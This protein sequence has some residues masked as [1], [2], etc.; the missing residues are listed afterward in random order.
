MAVQGGRFGLIG[1][2]GPLEGHGG[3]FQ[4]AVGEVAAQQGTHAVRGD[5]MVAAT[6][7][8][9]QPGQGLSGKMS[10]RRT[11]RQTSTS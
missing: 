5:E 8:A 11:D 7:E 10:S 2:L 3:L 6:Q 4:A 9:E 1:R